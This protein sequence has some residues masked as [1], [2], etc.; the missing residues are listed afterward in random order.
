MPLELQRSYT[1]SSNGSP[2][3]ARRE[4]LG[5]RSKPWSSARTQPVTAHDS[6][7]GRSGKLIVATRGPDGPGEVLVEVRG[8]TEAFICWSEQPLAKGTDVLVY[9]FRGE[10]TVDVMEWS[11]PAPQGDV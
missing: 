10:R 7:I 3:P 1:T 8:G 2:R 5:G 4:S 9:E 11:D 6:P